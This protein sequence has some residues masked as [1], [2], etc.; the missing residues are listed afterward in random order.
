VCV[1]VLFFLFQRKAS[2]LQDDKEEAENPNT[3]IWA[4]FEHSSKNVDSQ[5]SLV[6]DE[7]KESEVMILSYVQNEHP[8]PSSYTNTSSDYA[9]S[10]I[11]QE[12]SEASDKS[13][14]GKEYLSLS[15]EDRTAVSTSLKGVI[16]AVVAMFEVTTADMDHTSSSSA[17]A[18]NSKENEGTGNSSSSGDNYAESEDM[19]TKS[20]KVNEIELRMKELED[21]LKVQQLAARRMIVRERDSLLYAHIHIYVYMLLLFL[22]A[23][24]VVSLTPFSFFFSSAFPISSHFFEP[25]LLASLTIEKKLYLC[26]YICI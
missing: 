24:F 14:F 8:S 26:T 12:V 6:V 23:G 5:V 9:F 3:E 1:C 21:R 11:S 16:S 13:K 17:A 20:D 10:S 18:S 4:Q 15:E 22:S 2:L 19:Q 25:P 7:I